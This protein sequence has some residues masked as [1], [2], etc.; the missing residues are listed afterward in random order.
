MSLKETFKTILQRV[1][2]GC[3]TCKYPPA[4]WHKGLCEECQLEDFVAAAASEQDESVCAATIAL[5]KS[6]R[7]HIYQNVCELGITVKND[8]G[9]VIP[10]E[11]MSVKFIVKVLVDEIKNKR[12][13]RS[14]DDA[15]NRGDGTY[16]P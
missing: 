2:R 16:Q 6:I 11:E 9:E 10:I 12:H 7:E 3:D 1:T 15:L 13:N 8:K 14:V 5:E 4:E